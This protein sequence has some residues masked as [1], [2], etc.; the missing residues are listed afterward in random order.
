MINK[1]LQKRIFSS[2]VL[3]PV[4]IFFIFQELFFF[5]FFLSIFFLI[6]SYEWIKMNKKDILKIIGIFYLLFA[7]SMTYLLREKFSIGIFKKGPPDAVRVIK[8]TFA[9]LFFSRH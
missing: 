3:I 8:S 6:S 4:T 9:I 7:F 5:T 1:E 2:V